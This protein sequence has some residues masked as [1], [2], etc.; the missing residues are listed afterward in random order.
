MTYPILFRRKVLSVR[1]KENLSTAQVAQRFCVGVA[2][3]TRWIK[4]PDPQD[5]PQQ[6]FKQDW[7]GDFGAGRQGP[8][9]RVSVRVRRTAWS[10]HLSNCHGQRDVP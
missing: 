6:A 8:Y 1:D 4:T 7:H 5:H 2:S 9:G 10:Q 3:M